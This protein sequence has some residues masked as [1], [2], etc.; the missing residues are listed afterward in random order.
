MER[1]FVL[2]NPTVHNFIELL[3]NI[4]AQGFEN[5]I[6][7]TYCPE[8]ESMVTVTGVLYNTANKTIELQTDEN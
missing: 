4:A 8:T 6:V 1:Y 2:D 3:E 7:V 5:D